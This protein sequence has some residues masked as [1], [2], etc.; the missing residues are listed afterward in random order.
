[1]TFKF[2]DPTAEDLQK[3]ADTKARIEKNTRQK[4]FEFFRAIHHGETLTVAWFLQE[5]AHMNITQWTKFAKRFDQEVYPL[6]MAM[7]CNHPDIVDLLLL[8]GA[9]KN[10]GTS[11]GHSLE[12]LIHLAVTL[13]SPEMVQSLIEAGADLSTAGN[14]FKAVRNP[15]HFEDKAAPKF[16]F[17]SIGRYTPADLAHRLAEL[18]MPQTKQRFL[19]IAD[20]IET[21]I[22]QKPAARAAAKPAPRR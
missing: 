3:L 11:A 17:V 16:N 1:M 6:E 7:L 9:D 21:A 2:T 10:A 20:M 13:C 19:Q 8:F 4:N 22:A 18:A 15:A 14:G 12:R 5:N